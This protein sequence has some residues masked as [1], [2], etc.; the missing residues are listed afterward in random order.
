M[1]SKLV[2]I[3]YNYLVP[4][5]NSNGGTVVDSGTILTFMEKPVFDHVQDPNG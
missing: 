4:D 3:L 1:G 5:G 2:N